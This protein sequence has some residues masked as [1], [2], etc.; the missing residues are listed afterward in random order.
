MILYFPVFLVPPLE[1]DR[2]GW[3][4]GAGN[5]AKFGQE[6][7]IQRQ[8]NEV[9]A[10]TDPPIAHLQAKKELFPQGEIGWFQ[11][12]D[13]LIEE[14]QSGMVADDRQPVVDETK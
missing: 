14:A 5:K 2:A 4:K 3:K 10:P 6:T 12:R 9:T 13:G 11:R 8:I 1:E 7:L